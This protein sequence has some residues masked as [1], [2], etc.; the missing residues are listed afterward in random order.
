[1]SYRIQSVQKQIS[2][3][4][5][6]LD[7]IEIRKSE[8]V[9]QTAIPLDL[10]RNEQRLREKLTELQSELAALSGAPQQI[11]SPAR[12]RRALKV[13]ISAGVIIVVAAAIFIWIRAWRDKP[14]GRER[15]L[16]CWGMAQKLKDK[17][18][19]GE[20]ARLFGSE[21]RVDPNDELRFFFTSPDAGR[22]YLLS[23]ETAKAG[24]L[25]NLLFP[26][27]KG[28]NSLSLIPA[29][30]EIV[31]DKVIFEGQ[32]A[33]EKLWVIWTVSPM[34]ELEAEITKW[35]DPAYLGEIQDKALVAAI[36]AFIEQNANDNPP[37]EEDEANKRLVW[38]SKSDII[39][40]PLRINVTK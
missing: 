21:M 22:L 36:K 25:Y 4:E 7:L 10:I 23:E 5:R 31:T 16:S 39:V 8:F 18:P 13:A 29:N 20:P 12:N 28:N 15:I 26:T 34:A 19:Y 38:K 6:S 2:E 40:K 3:I 30:A 35:R 24:A 1:M 9:S 32:A 14:D 17:K 37:G 33:T 27:P 11:G